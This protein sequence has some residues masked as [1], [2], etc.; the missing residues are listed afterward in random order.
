M[1]GSLGLVASTLPVQWLMPLLGWR[2]LFWVVGALFILAILL[3]ARVV[4]ADQPVVASPS[5]STSARQGGYAEVFRHPIFLRCLPM[6]FFQYGSMVALQSLWVG[7]WL[8]RVCGW[9]AYQTAVGLFAI[10]VA[11]LLTFMGWGV[12]VPRL[13][14]RGWTVHALIAWGMPLS[15]VMLFVGVALDSEA[16]AW[17]WALFCV[18]A[19][20]W[21]CR[22]LRSDKRL[23]RRLPVEP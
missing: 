15:L 13:S 23:R 16:T 21:R 14:A 22:S 11:M 8:T 3:I 17:V 7:P 6:A 12:A 4:P 20:V 18:Q 9:S 2:G 19:P 10:N 5:T 1:T